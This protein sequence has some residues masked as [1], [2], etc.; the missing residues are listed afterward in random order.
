M[1][2]DAI[3]AV[4]QRI[5]SEE[6][7]V[8]PQEVAVEST[9]A[10]NLNCIMCSRNR[11]TRKFG[12]ISW[13]LYKKIVEEIAQK[14]KETTRLWLCFFGEPLLRKD[15]PDMVLHAKQNGLKNVVINSNMNT[16]R[17]GIAEALVK[18]GMN[19]IFAS[20]DALTSS[21]YSTIRRG[22]SFEKVV[23]N[24]LE[25]QEMLA[26]Y[27]DS[28][29]QI[30]VQFIEMEQNSD[31]KN[32]VINFWHEYGIDVK[33]RPL[34][35]F[36][37]SNGIELAISELERQPCHWAMNIMPISPFGECVHCGTDYDGK[38]IYGDINYSTIEDIWNTTKKELRLIHLNHQ[39]EKLPDFCL[40][41]PD[42]VS[43]YATY[44]KMEII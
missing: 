25:Y 4:K 19:T 13:D 1:G 23:K 24:V 17:P 9:T 15:L 14:A 22:G 12:Q 37:N 36:Q 35:T 20:V 39:W 2:Q 33:I 29:Q 27:G 40:N 16:L 3:Q 7:N 32:D 6:K 28:E 30:I 34:I 31:Q 8:F 5:I 42:W 21:V 26:K 11:L 10:C 44:D 18:N 41:C 43:A 38:K